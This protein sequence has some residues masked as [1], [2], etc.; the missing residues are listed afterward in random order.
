[1]SELILRER[2]RPNDWNANAFD[3]ENFPKLV[4]SIREKGIMEPLKVMPDPEH[5]G[6]FLLVDGYHRWKAAGDLGL[7]EVPCEVWDISPEEA[8][9]RG[10]Q[11]NYLRGQP[12]PVRLANLVHDLNRTYAVDDLA[13]ILPW[14]ESQLRDSLELLKLPADLQGKL[15]AQA[16]QEAA[17]APVPVTVVLLGKEHASFEAAMQQAKQRLGKGARRGECLAA[18]CS[19]FISEQ[20]VAEENSGVETTDD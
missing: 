2:I 17:E 12:I 3:P 4:E 7:Q 15:E 18:I 20:A 8:K 16:A 11:L 19:Q 1:M 6:D 14:S 10:L 9:V 5:E 13:K